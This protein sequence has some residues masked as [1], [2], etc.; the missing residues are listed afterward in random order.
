MRRLL[1][2]I[3]QKCEISCVKLVCSSIVLVQLATVR[4]AERDRSHFDYGPIPRISKIY[5]GYGR[6]REGI[7]S[8]TKIQVVHF[9]VVIYLL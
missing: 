5:D 2:G 3:V 7:R 8:L 9:T 1:T 4:H 6:V